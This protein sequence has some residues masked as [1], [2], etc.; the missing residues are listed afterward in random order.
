MFLF[1][2]PLLFGFACNLASAFVTAFSHRWG[3][4]RGSILTAI[5]R[6][7]L[8]IPVW[9]SGFLVAVWTPSPVLFPSSAVTYIAGWVTV[10]IGSIIILVALAT[11]QR[12]AAQPSVRDTL[13][14][15]GIYAHVRHPIHTGTMLEFLGLLLLVPTL[16]VACACVLGIVWVLAQT[17]LEEI[18]L[19]QRLP[20]YG[21][22]MHTVPR[23]LPHLW[24]K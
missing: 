16:T 21:E 2:F 13:V 22:Y 3:E 12:K 17:R 24:K 6:N 5:L 14:Q 19:L 10:I 1:L 9:G 18:D 4:R 11:I 15:T 20:E 23:F 7:V 8:G